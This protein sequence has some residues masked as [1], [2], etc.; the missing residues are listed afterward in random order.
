MID[1]VINHPK[2]LVSSELLKLHRSVSYMTFILKE[3]YEYT[4]AKAQDGTPL[5]TLRNAKNDLITLNEKLSI[6]K[7]KSY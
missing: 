7:A 6:L 3:I 5:Y 1:L 2:V 4:I